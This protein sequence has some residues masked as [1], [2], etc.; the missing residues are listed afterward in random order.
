MNK[1]YVI[2]S[3]FIFAFSAMGMAVTYTAPTFT[4]DDGKTFTDSKFAN[5]YVET[6]TLT[7]GDQTKTWNYQAPRVFWNVLTTMTMDAKGGETISARFVA[8]SLGEYSESTVKQDLRYTAVV[9]A[10]DWNGDGEFESVQKIKGDTPPA[11]NVGGNMDVLDFTYD[12]VVPDDV[13][14]GTARVRFNYTNAW[15]NKIGEEYEPL[16]DYVERAKTTCK[17]GVVYDFDVNVSPK[18]VQN[19]VVTVTSNE[20]AQ[21]SLLN[22]T[23]TVASGS[24]VPEGTELTVNVVPDDGWKVTSIKANEVNI[25]DSRTFVVNG[26][27][28]VSVEV[29]EM[30]SGLVSY[31]IVGDQSYLGDKGV[32]LYDGDGNLVE[33]NRKWEEGSAYYI[34]VYVKDNTTQ[35]LVT[36][37]TLS[38]ELEKYEDTDVIAY[39]YEGI[40][41][42]DQNLVITLPGGTSGLEPVVE[43]IAHYNPGQQMLCT[44]GSSVLIY[45]LSGRLLLSGS[46]NVSVSELADGF[47]AAVVDGR[48]IKF[49]K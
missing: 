23:E 10:I 1:F 32:E 26:A 28:T 3:S 18:V 27:T 41:E 7:N 22:G 11:H 40:V 43:A 24:E 15:K 42:G 17:E 37:N 34:Y 21:I 46:G 2:L 47:Y 35:V 31:S 4:A 39:Y 5:T 16:E 48:T 6:I 29:V 38:V 49:K 33:N 30:Q 9:L 36:L 44:N 8:H 13:Q 12:I 20:H 14:V 19:Y 25:T 45:D